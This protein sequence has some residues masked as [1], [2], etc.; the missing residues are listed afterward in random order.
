MED[1]AGYAGS[2]SG[3]VGSERVQDLQNATG[4]NNAGSRSETRSVSRGEKSEDEHEKELTENARMNMLNTHFPPLDIRRSNGS[5][6]TEGSSQAHPD[7]PTRAVHTEE[8]ESSRSTAPRQN[9]WSARPRIDP[10][11]GG[12]A[13]NVYLDGTISGWGDDISDE[14]MHK[15]IEEINRIDPPGDPDAAKKIPW[16]EEDGKL[17][18][19]RIIGIHE[20]EAD[21]EDEE[22]KQNPGAEPTSRYTEELFHP[23]KNS[24]KARAEERNST[25][26]PNT[27]NPYEQLADINEG[28]ADDEGTEETASRQ[29]AARRS[30]MGVASPPPPPP[31]PP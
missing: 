13:R 7:L 22:E 18:K 17:L 10:N 8:G 29:R 4:E 30:L 14:E 2:G 6:R 21:S 1:D 5:R 27:S 3:T 20:R 16:E 11:R 28:E 31:P 24:A 9:A 25:L 23:V 15:I 12:R 26:L 19:I